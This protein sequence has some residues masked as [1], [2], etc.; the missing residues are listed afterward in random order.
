MPQTS[1]IEQDTA[2]EAVRLASHACRAVQQKLVAADTL[3]KK[4]RSPVTVADYA[5]QAIVCA[6]IS[7]EFPDDPVIGEEDATELRRDENAT[8]RHA[9][10]QQVKA[11]WDSTADEKQIL[12]WIDH[13][14]TQASSGSA[15]RFWTLDPIDGTKGFLRNEQYAVALALLEEG[16]VVMGVLGCPNLPMGD[17][18]GALLVAVRGEGAKA[19]PLWDR[20]ADARAIKV[21]TVAD[22]SQARF[23]ESVE[24]GHSDQGASAQIAALLGITGDPV[25]M[26]SQAKYAAIARGDAS[27]YLRLPTRAD[28]QEKIWD[29]A[30]GSIVVEEAGGKVTD[31]TGQPLDFSLGKT[32]ANNR[33][34]IATNSLIHDQVVQAVQESFEGS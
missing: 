26:D 33:G 8:I 1:Q 7:E 25:R 29:H 4:D 31:I 23:C 24:S 12:E 30:A 5:S 15:A 11:A 17:Q 6:A 18:T 34:V 3:E 32:L 22:P 27:I 14:V 2:I 19:Y 13:G 28:Y 9:V 16:R 10:V 20:A 21:S